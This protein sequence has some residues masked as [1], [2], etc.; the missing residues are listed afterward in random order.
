MPLSFPN[1]YLN[2]RGRIETLSLN[3]L[4]SIRNAARE[5]PDSTDIQ[6]QL[7]DALYNVRYQPAEDTFRVVP[8]LA[9]GE[10]YSYLWAHDVATQRGCP[11][12]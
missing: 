7:R 8:F 2:T 12:N 1:V 6:V 3:I 9:E 11:C 10:T 4:E 5:M